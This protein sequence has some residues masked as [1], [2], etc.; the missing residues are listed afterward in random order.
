MYKHAR[1]SIGL[2]QDIAAFHL[3]ICKRKLSDVENGLDTPDPGTVLEMSRVYGKPQLPVWY[4]THECPIGKEYHYQP[5]QMNPAEAVLRFMKEL[6]DLQQKEVIQKLI[7]VFHDGKVT[8]DEM[9]IFRQSMYEISDVIEASFGIA[10][11][12]GVLD[13]REIIR[14]KEKPLAYARG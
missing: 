14:E 2:T 7:E 12:N 4:C 10:D 3:P 9:P 8:P 6:N 5:R 13:R 11:S 1:D